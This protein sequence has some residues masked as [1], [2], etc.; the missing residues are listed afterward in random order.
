MLN[1][2]TKEQ[3]NGQNETAYPRTFQI[4]A[5]AEL[6]FP[7]CRGLHQRLWRQHFLSPGGAVRQRHFRYVHTPFPDHAGL[8]VPVR[9]P[10]DSERSAFPV[11]TEKAGD[12]LY[13]LFP[14]CRRRVLGCVVDHRGCASRGRELCVPAGGGRSAPV[15][16]VRRRDLR[17]GQRPDNP[18]WRCDRRRGGHG[19]HFRKEAEPDRRHLCHDLQRHF[20]HYL[21]QCDAQLDSAPLLHR[22]LWG[23]AENR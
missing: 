3:Q 8:S 20:V 4:P 11:R 19:G 7:V 5:V 2:I 9:L 16:P 23:G 13:R 22:G 15:R 21:R 18:L 17:R 12:G 10:S 6:Y 1:Q 14:V